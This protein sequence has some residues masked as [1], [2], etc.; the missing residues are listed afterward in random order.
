MDLRQ[1]EERQQ[2][3][4]PPQGW[5][6][7]LGCYDRRAF[8]RAIGGAGLAAPS[9]LRS[10]AMLLG[11]GAALLQSGGAYSAR[12]EPLI[13]PSEIR[14]QNGVLDATLTAAPGTVQLD[15][16]TFPGSSLVIDWPISTSAGS[17]WRSRTGCREKYLP[18]YIAEFSFRY[19]NRLNANIF[20]SAIAGC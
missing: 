8:L 3:A 10:S 14:S 9:V 6:P 4:R 18:L 20:G 16:V 12:R 2:N 19:N 7:A 5:Y 17:A 13:Q 11:P 15:E 1:P